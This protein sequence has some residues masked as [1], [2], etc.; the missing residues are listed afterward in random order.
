[1]KFV[2][3]LLKI[4]NESDYQYIK[5]K[6]FDANQIIRNE[7]EKCEYVDFILHGEVLISSISLLGN[8]QVFNQLKEN[9]T[10]G[11]ILVFSSEPLYLGDVIAKSANTEIAS[12][13]K[14]NLITIFQ[15]NKEFME[16]YF[17][18]ICNETLESKKERKLLLQKTIADRIIYLLESNGGSIIINTITDLANMLSYP[19]PSMSRVVNKLIDDG[20]VTFKNKKLSLK[21]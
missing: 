21:A 7:K 15:H 9:D 4:L 8:E 16:K 1:M 6:K 17:N 10:L 19:R 14:D 12:I 20:V 5:I 18:Q 11:N 2:H 3:P 13:S